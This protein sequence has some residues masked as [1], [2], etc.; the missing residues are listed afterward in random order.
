[1]Q[2]ADADLHGHTRRNLYLNYAIQIDE[3]SLQLLHMTHDIHYQGVKES[4]LWE[5]QICSRHIWGPYVNPD[6]RRCVRQP[7]FTERKDAQGNALCGI[8]SH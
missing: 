8:R 7:L 5:S 6:K 3:K 4:E 1:M 2:E